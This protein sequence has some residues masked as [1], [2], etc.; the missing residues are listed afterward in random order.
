MLSSAD[1]QKIPYIIC[2]G[3]D[4]LKTEKFKLKNLKTGEEVT[5]EI[6]QILKCV[7]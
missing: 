7:R 2:I 6:N 3:E 5:E 4:E 1:K